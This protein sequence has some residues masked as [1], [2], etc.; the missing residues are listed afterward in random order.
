M[1][2]IFFTCFASIGLLLS[3]SEDET[4][5]QQEAQ[6]LAN[7]LTEIKKM[8]AS[9]TCNDPLKWAFTAIGIKVCGGPTSYIPYS[10]N[11]D[12]LK[13]LNNVNDYNIAEEKFQ[14]KWGIYSDCKVIRKPSK[15]IC[16][17]GNPV[18]EY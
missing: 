14:K 13:F 18:F 3:C 6:E 12:T 7:M 1:K 5:Q 10:K 2:K 8:S 11:I 4:T 15:I 9:E 16:Q 17:N